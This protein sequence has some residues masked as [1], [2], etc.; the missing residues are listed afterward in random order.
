MEIE[1]EVSRLIGDMG[2]LWLEVS[3][4]P[5]AD[6]DRAYIERNLIALL[7]GPTGPIDL[8]S[9]SWL[10]RWSSR[11][12]VRSSGMWNVNHVYEIYD[13]DVIAILEEY[14][15][16]AEGSRARDNKSRARKNWRS[17]AREVRGDNPQIELI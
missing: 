14:V 10:G 4:E 12:A 13:P 5:S 17:Q 3:D 1:L 11:D 6:S 16:I 2:V 15:E 8:P 9:D 7:S